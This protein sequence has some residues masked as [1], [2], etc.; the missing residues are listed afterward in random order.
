MRIVIDAGHGP[1]T[2]G[3]RSPDGTLREYQF[4]SATARYLAGLLFDYQGIEILTVYEDGRDVP[5]TER[6]NKANSWGAHLYVSV[7][8]N[9]NGNGGW[10]SANGIE[11]FVYTTRPAAAVA[12]ANAV[13]RRLI[14]ATGLLDRGVKS[15]DFHVLRETNMTAVL[16]ECGF[17]TNKAEAELL[18]SDDYRQKVAAALAAAIA[19]T[20]G[21]TKKESVPVTEPVKDWKQEAV[22]WLHE[23]GLTDEIRDPDKTPTWAE[24]GAVLSKMK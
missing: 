13:Q 10:D 2:A 5:L 16:V 12:L 6:T 8:A 7:H 9:A 19:E 15:A 20:Y 24:L 4:N 21:L 17:M 18:K 3:K 1:D 14:A 23:Q 11:T 22:E